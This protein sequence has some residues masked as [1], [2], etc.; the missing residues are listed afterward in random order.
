MIMQLFG[1]DTLLN[2]R[3]TIPDI[4]HGKLTPILGTIG[5]K[6]IFS[7][8]VCILAPFLIFNPIN[9]FALIL[10]SF[11]TWSSGAVLSICVGLTVYSA[12]K[13]KRFRKLI[14]I[15]ALLIP[16]LFAWQTG[17]IK[18]FSSKAGR[19]PV[20]LKTLQLSIERPQGYGV[21]TY[22]ILFPIL[23]GDEIRIQQPGK[24]WNTCH[25]DWLQI[26]FETGFIGFFLLIGWVVSIVKNVLN[27]ANYVKLTGLLIIATNMLVHFP[28]RMCMS[29]LIMLAFLAYCSQGEEYGKC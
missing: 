20:Y 18:T 10:V 26:L 3:E 1:R 6:M 8:F 13:F 5:N 22:K 9:W 17:K 24:E 29:V 2:F 14:I 21:G 12:N 27:D 28:Q 19:L 16:L 23:C 25:N 11:I 7:S 4:L 15:L